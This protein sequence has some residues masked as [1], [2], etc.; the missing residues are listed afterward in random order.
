MSK[1]VVYETSEGIVAV[2]SPADESNIKKIADKGVP[3]GTSYWIV[4]S[5][6]IPEEDQ[7]SWELINM[8]TPDG[9][10]Q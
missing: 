5:A 4:D 3:A 6:E 8:P 7:E 10:G 9:V 2:M 1:K